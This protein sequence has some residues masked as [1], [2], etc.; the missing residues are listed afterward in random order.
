MNW[1]KLS[2]R[3]SRENRAIRENKGKR[4]SG[5]PDMLKNV[6]MDKGW[7]WLLYLDVILPLLLFIF[8]Y[9]LS[10]FEAGHFMSRLFH[11]YNLYILSPVPVLKNLSGFI[12]LFIHTGAVVYAIRRKNLP[13]MLLCVGF[14]VLAVLYILLGVHYKL[15]FILNPV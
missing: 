6:K 9:I 15:I 7:H 8:A 3:R 5:I 10:V 1:N 12:G 11:A 4:G 2:G 13:D 14:A